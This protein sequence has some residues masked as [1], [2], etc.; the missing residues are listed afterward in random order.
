MTSRSGCKKAEMGYQYVS[1]PVVAPHSR[2][3]DSESQINDWLSGFE[4]GVALVFSSF[5]IV[6]PKICHSF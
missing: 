2:F 5:R 3:Q 6:Y 1:P 4:G